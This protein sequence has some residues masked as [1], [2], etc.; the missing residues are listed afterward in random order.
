MRFSEFRH[1]CRNILDRIGKDRFVSVGLALHDVDASSQFAQVIRPAAGAFLAG[2]TVDIRS[3]RNPKTLAGVFAQAAEIAARIG[4]DPEITVNGDGTVM[5]GYDS[6]AGRAVASYDFPEG[7]DLAES[8]LDAPKDE[9]DPAVWRDPDSGRPSLSDGAARTIAGIRK[10]ARDDG[11]IGPAAGAHVTGSI[12]SN[13]YSEESDVDVH[14]YGDVDFG[15]EDPADYNARFRKAFAGFAAE[16]PEYS[17]IG[18]HPVEVYAQPNEFQDMMSVGCYDVDSG[19]WL[20]GPGAEDTAFDP[21]SEYYEDDM[22]YAGGLV[23]DIRSA[24]LAA[25]EKAVVYRKST[26][27]TFREKIGE[28][29]LADAARAARLFDRIRGMRKA[30]SSPASKEEALALRGD[31]RWRVAD[32]AFKLLD[33]FGYTA[34]CKACRAAADGGDAASAAEAV[35]D[36]VAENIAGNAALSEEDRAQWG[37]GGDEALREGLGSALRA[38]ALAGMTMAAGAAGGAVGKNGGAE[39]GK[40]PAAQA[41]ARAPAKEPSYAGLS[42]SNMTNLLATIAYNEA[43]L[44]WM[45]DRNDDKL[46]AILNV[47][48]NRAGKDPNRYASVISAKSQF[49]SAKHVKG[50]YADGTYRTYD[51]DDEAKAEGG[52]LSPRQ[53]E[54]WALCQKYARDMLDKKLPSRI[55]NRNM[56]ANKGKDSAASYGAWG[57]KCD[58]TIGDHAFGYDPAHD[59]G[60]KKAP[61]RYVVRPGDTLGRIAKGLGTTV[62]E[63]AKKNGIRNPNAIKIGQV[64]KI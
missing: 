22:E 63:L 8:V 30:V 26:D 60:A 41:P 6:Q 64:L 23:D 42:R 2:K 38:A 49:F 46:I 19:E 4:G 52:R 3:G 16:N 12:A 10:W 36:A 62:A 55:G 18:G 9:M 37:F 25:Y 58:L 1:E 7:E 54:C 51:P 21:Y 45:K 20:S 28:G 43:M 47:I 24:A 61:A 31:R 17:E 59:P 29:L 32:S 33:K 57:R 13:Q 11:W 44:D 39:A 27:E 40:P 48:D 34:V 56:I 15:G 5:L 53:R 35:L 50:G 14:F